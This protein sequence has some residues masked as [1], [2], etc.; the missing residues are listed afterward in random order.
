M[1]FF[2]EIYTIRLIRVHI[3]VWHR[4][5][6]FAGPALVPLGKPGLRVK[7]LD[8]FLSLDGSDTLCRLT[9]EGIL[10]KSMFL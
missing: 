1:I 2:K 5:T 4:A 3:R 6:N 8:R 10:V 9:F 7:I